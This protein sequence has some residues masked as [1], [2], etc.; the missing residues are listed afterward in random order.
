MFGSYTVY[1]ILK[2]H[3]MLILGN[4]SEESKTSLKIPKPQKNQASYILMVKKI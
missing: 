2:P 1:D 4:N 3:K